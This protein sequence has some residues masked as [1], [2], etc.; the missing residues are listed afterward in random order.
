MYQKIANKLHQLESLDSLM[1]TPNPNSAKLKMFKT[2]LERLMAVLQLSKSNISPGLKEKL[3]VYEKQII[4]FINTNRPRKPVSS[5]NLPPSEIH[6]AHML[7]QAKVE[8]QDGQQCQPHPSQQ[9]YFSE[10][11]PQIGH[12]QQHQ[13]TLQQHQLSL[14]QQSNPLQRDMQHRL[15]AS[16]QVSGA[17]L[18]PPNT[19]ELQNQLY[20]S[21][22]SLSETSS[23]SL[24]YPAQTGH[25]DWQ[26]EAN[27]KIKVMK[28][29]YFAELSETYWKIATKLQLDSHLQQQ[30]SDQYDKLSML[31]N[32]LEDLIIVLHYSKTDISLVLKEQLVFYEK[33][34]VDFIDTNRIR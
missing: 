7:Q 27:Q 34:I 32:K 1:S 21:H 29:L 15:Q 23:S 2:M 9:K 16:G 11:Q 25:T 30:T 14:Q 28:H 4:N 33:Q 13:L 31:K 22:R 19:M 6:N 8:P 10:I 5:L 26:E 3:N 20:Q 12:M 24:D 17:I 18:Q